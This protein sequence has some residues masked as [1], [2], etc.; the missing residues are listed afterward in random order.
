MLVIPRLELL[1]GAR[2]RGDSAHILRS[3]NAVVAARAWAAEGYSRL[4][5][6][7]RD[8]KERRSN[9]GLVE[10][11]ARGRCAEGHDTGHARRTTGYGPM[12]SAFVAHPSSSTSRIVTAR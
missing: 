12:S 6:V 5:V 7:E 3:D 2:P 4:Q 1:G 10:D 11:L 9:L 8:S